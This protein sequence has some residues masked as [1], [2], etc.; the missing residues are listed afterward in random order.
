MA[1]AM[2]VA[3]VANAAAPSWVEGTT[4]FNKT[5]TASGTVQGKEFSQKWEWAVGPGLPNLQGALSQVQDST[6]NKII[7]PILQDTPILVGRTKQA[8]SVPGQFWKGGVGAIPN[9]NF[10]NNGQAAKLGDPLYAGG[11]AFISI[12]VKDRSN[13]KIGTAKLNVTTAGIEVVKEVNYHAQQKVLF[14]PDNASIFYGGLPSKSEVVAKNIA[15][16]ASTVM[17]FGGLSPEEMKAQVGV[18]SFAPIDNACSNENM[19][20]SPGDKVSASY[21]LGFKSGNAIE[22]TFDSGKKPASTTTWSAS[23]GIQVTY[24]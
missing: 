19:A 16:T 24:N 3:G 21:A 10:K 18:T 15:A 5:F 2:S 23:L 20:Y 11:T 7:I 8:F 1:V 13:A 14:A 4:P 22:V 17:S 9:I 12:D 6:G